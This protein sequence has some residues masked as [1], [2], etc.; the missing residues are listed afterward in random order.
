MV[1]MPKMRRSTFEWRQNA[2]DAGYESTSSNA[3]IHQAK[4]AHSDPSTIG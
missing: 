2:A 3:T 4:E 1:R